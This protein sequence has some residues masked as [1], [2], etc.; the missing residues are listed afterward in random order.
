MSLDKMFIG[1]DGRDYAT[2]EGLRQAEEAWNT[3]HF[4]YIGDDGRFYSTLEALQAANEAHFRANHRYIVY[5][6]ELGKREIAPGTGRVQVCVG[7][8]IERDETGRRRDVPV[9]RTETF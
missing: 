6:A 9:Y 3:E 7:H 5:D 8:L 1:P 2:I 4:Q